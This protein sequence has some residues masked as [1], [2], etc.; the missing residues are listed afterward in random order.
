MERNNK[1]RTIDEL[2]YGIAR[3]VRYLNKNALRQMLVDM[4]SAYC[5]EESDYYD[6]LDF[7]FELY[8]LK[9]EE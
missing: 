2:I 5:A 1:F 8:G 3:Y 4:I 9:E 6:K 7:A